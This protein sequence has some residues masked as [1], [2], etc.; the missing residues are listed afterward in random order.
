MLPCHWKL[1]ASRTSN[2]SVIL[3]LCLL[4]MYLL[5]QRSLAMSD[6]YIQEL[7]WVRYANI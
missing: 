7:R 2:Q 3:W 1:N 6:G 4:T 5:A